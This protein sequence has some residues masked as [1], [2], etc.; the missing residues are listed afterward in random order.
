MLSARI[1]LNKSIKSPWRKNTLVWIEKKGLC[2]INFAILTKISPVK[3]SLWYSSSYNLIP[4]ISRV[5]IGWHLIFCSP[6]WPTCCNSSRKCTRVK[7]KAR[8]KAGFP[9]VTYTTPILTCA[10]HIPLVY[11]LNPNQ[12]VFIIFS[13]SIRMGYWPVHLKLV[14]LSQMLNNILNT[15][16]NNKIVSPQSSIE[17]HLLT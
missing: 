7:Y 2:R 8:Q 14:P 11:L 6:M 16:H 12:R 13:G 15:I 4:A 10:I 1:S 9:I 3:S 17:I 5:L